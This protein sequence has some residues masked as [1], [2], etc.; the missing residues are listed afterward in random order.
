MNLTKIFHQNLTK[1]ELQLCQGMNSYVIIETFSYLSHASKI[2]LGITKIKSKINLVLDQEDDFEPK[3]R[4][5]RSYFS[6]EG[7]HR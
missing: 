1:A 2:L 4:N 5:N 6:R 7:S 3:T